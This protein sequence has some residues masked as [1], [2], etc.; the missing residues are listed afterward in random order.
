MCYTERKREKERK[1]ALYQLCAA[2]WTGYIADGVVALWLLI[3]TLVCGKKGFINCIFGIV[4]TLVAFL[5]AVSLANVFLE[6]T[7]GLFGLQAW[8]A[9]EFEKIFLGLEGFDGD[10]S[11]SGVE[12]ALETNNVPAV[13]ARLVLKLTDG[14]EVAAGTT[15]ALLVGEAAASLAASLVAGLVIFL[16]VK[17]GVFFLKKILNGVVQKLSLLRS[18]NTLLGS[19]FGLLYALLIVSL[20][21][22]VLATI[23]VSGISAYF[24]KTLF[25]GA[26]YEHNPLVVILSWFL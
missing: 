25:V 20:L 26:L 19:L 13:L 5:L 9:E 11:A 16:L 8:F 24:S 21:L 2:E 4:S 6:G 7:G 12:A 22:A 15:L 3:T 10:I 17:F 18:V 23:P 1:M 14:A